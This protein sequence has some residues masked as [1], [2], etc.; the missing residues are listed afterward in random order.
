MN[1]LESAIRSVM[2]DIGLQQ[3]PEVAD[4]IGITKSALYKILR[5]DVGVTPESLR[6]LV[7]VSSEPRHQFVILSAHLYDQAERG[8]DLVGK[9]SIEFIDTPSGI[10][11]SDFPERLQ[12]E[13]RAIGDR[14]KDGDADLGAA[15][16]WLARAVEQPIGVSTEEH[17]ADASEA[18]PLAAEDQATYDIKPPAADPVV[19]ALQGQAAA[20]IPPP[21]APMQPPARKRKGKG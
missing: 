11:F 2:R 1:R 20:P 10:C 21:I 16:S 17:F 4:K 7:G 13:L 14:I 15:I 9:I 12:Y 5:G 6:R 19:A 8:S 18:L 3:L